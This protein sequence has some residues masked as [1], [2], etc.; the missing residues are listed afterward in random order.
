[1]IPIFF[2]SDHTA[3]LHTICD[4][5]TGHAIYPDLFYAHPFREEALLDTSAYEQAMEQTNGHALSQFVFLLVS[6][7]DTQAVHEWLESLPAEIESIADHSST[8]SKE[9]HTSSQALIAKFADDLRLSV[10][11]QRNFE[12]LMEYYQAIDGNAADLITPFY[13]E[14]NLP[15]KT[16]KEGMQLY[17]RIKNIVLG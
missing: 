15:V 1:M 16:K 13:Q 12:Q 2:P 3:I 7:A 9:T 17:E 5:V 14:Y 4:P 10:S 8:P 6:E 11:L